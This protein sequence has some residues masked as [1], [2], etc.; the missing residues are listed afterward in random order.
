MVADRSGKSPR[1]HVPRRSATL[2]AM[3]ATAPLTADTGAAPSRAWR[4]LGALLVATGALSV[5]AWAVRTGIVLRYPYQLDYM[6]GAALNWAAWAQAGLGLY[7]PIGDGPFVHHPYMPLYMGLVNACGRLGWVNLPTMRLVSVLPTAGTAVV[8]AIVVRRR[9]GGWVVPLLAAGLWL[10]W[11]AV[12]VY[13]VLVR[14]EPLAVFLSTCGFARL[15]ATPRGA[16][17][18]VLWFGLAIL[19]KQPYLFTAMVAGVWLLLTDRRVALRYAVGMALFGAAMLALTW[20]RTGTN[21]WWHTV[22]ATNNQWTW[23]PVLRWARFNATHLAVPVLLAAAAT[24]RDI[25]S[26]SVSPWGVYFV[27]AWLITFTVGKDG[28]ALH[29]FVEVGAPTAV[30]AAAAAARI[31]QRTQLRWLFAAAALAVG[32]VVPLRHWPGR[33][34]IYRYDFTPTPDVR[35]ERDAVVAWVRGQP[36]NVLCYDLDLVA[37][38][39]QACALQPWMFATLQREGLWDE[40]P[41]L[42]QVR[43]G[44]FAAILLPYPAHLYAQLPAVAVMYSPGFNAAVVERYRLETVLPY[45]DGRPWWYCYRYRPE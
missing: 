32:A 1:V 3:S 20:W 5:A 33:I 25:R 19:C 17:E 6:E 34:P 26:R 21:F 11:P 45:G 44:D 41:L 31:A 16:T 22:V 39:G 35:A 9:A 37:L 14:P 18:A 23:G 30:M 43:A 13:G 4:L 24:V 40:A 8:L 15:R 7:H 36:G 2:G 12:Y 28:S 10:S 29:Y 27:G 42:A 38:A